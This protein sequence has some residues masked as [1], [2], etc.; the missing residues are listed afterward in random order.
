MIDFHTQPIMI[1]ELMETE[2]SL[3]SNIHNILGFFFPPQSLSVF[4]HEMDAAGINQ[5]VLLPIDCSSTH[6]CKIPSNESIASLCEKNDRFI[7][8]A[9]VDP[10]S[11]SAEVE[12]ESAFKKLGLKGLYLD[13]AVQRF[14]LESKKLMDP[15]F[16]TCIKYNR[17]VLVQCGINWSP[18]SSLK[19]ANPLLLEESIQQ[20]PKLKLVISNLGWPWYRE[21]AMLAMKYRNVYLD[22]ALMYS[23]TPKQIFT[24]LFGNILEKGIFERNLFFQTLYGSNFPRV[25]MRRTMR[26]MLSVGFSDEFKEHLFLKN[27]RTI[28]E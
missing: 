7:G 13:P 24:H 12:L 10:N 15:L 4:L 19:L 26:G 16:K 17:P 5:S 28:L 21:A 6:G 8:F 14:D 11:P 2:P 27:A 22:T 1:K 9:S 25:D 18:E 3:E 20:F 23:G